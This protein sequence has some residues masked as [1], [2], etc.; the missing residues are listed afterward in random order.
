MSSYYEK[1]LATG[2][3]KCIDEDIPFDIPTG[4]EWCRLSCL[5]SILGDGIHGTPEYDNTGDIYFV[6]GNNLN[7]G[8][9][10]IKDDT[11]RVNST[12]AAKHK[13]TL[14]ESTVLVS[15]N[16]NCPHHGR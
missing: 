14:T 9:I 10:T 8:I 15:I 1:F 3:V 13:R 16:R 6:N 7:D 2:E 11:K 12:E 4:W 5:T